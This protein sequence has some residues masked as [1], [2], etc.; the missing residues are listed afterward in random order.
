MSKEKAIVQP[1]DIPSLPAK[2][3]HSDERIRQS[4]SKPATRVH[5]IFGHLNAFWKSYG[6]MLLLLAIGI[7]AAIGHHKF[8]EY[9]D[10]Q[11]VD[12]VSLTQTWVI[13]IGNAFAFLFK[14]SFV[15]AIGNVFCQAFWFAI[16]RK[17]IRVGGIDAV[18]TVLQ[19]PLQF[20]NTELLFRTKRLVILAAISWILPISAIFSPGALTGA[21]LFI[22]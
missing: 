21:P 16:R 7:V 10:G 6:L 17:A 5:R 4:T 9:L 14:S 19:D 3:K 22:S 15:A 13:R 1:A 18:F 2:R 20:F 8:Y 11:P 12:E